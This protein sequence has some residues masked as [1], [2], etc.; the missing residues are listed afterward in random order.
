MLNAAVLLATVLLQVLP[1]PPRLTVS[2]WAD[3]YRILSA[4]ASGEPGQ[5]RTSRAEYQ[6]GIMD[7]LSSPVVLTLVAMCSAQVGKTEIVNNCVGFY[8]DQDP[9][10]VMVVQP[11]IQMAEAWSK[12]RLSPM[13]RDTPVLRNKVADVKSRDS[14]NTILDKSFPGGLLVIRGSNAPAGL[15]S[16]PIRVV[17]CDEVDRFDESAGTEGDPVDLAFKRTTTFTGRRKHVLIS[18]PGIKG[19]S[20]IEKAWN[21][22]DQR[23]YFVPCPHCGE[24]QHL[25]WK[26]VSFDPEAPEGAVYV[27]RACGCIITDA[28][29]GAMLRAGE[30]RATRPFNGTAG[31]HLN[32]MY[33]PWRRFGEIATDFMKAKRRGPESLKVWVNTSLGEPWDL[34]EGDHLQAEGL[35]ARARGSDYL[36]GAVAAAAGLLVAAVDVQDDRLEL[37]VWAVGLGEE[38][39]IVCHQIFPGNLAQ[40]DPWDRLQA[41]ILQPWPRIGGGVHHIRAAALDIGGHFTK[42]VY[43]FCRRPALRGKTHP[44]KG[45]TQPQA[46]L[47]RRSGA[48][49][50][51]WL[52]DTVAAKDQVLSRLRI[53]GPGFGHVHFPQDL[54]PALFDQFLAEKPVRRGGRRA[55]EKITADARNEGLDLLVYCAAALEIFNPSDLGVYVVR[56]ATMSQEAPAQEV[57]GGMKGA[58]GVEPPAETPRSAVADVPATPAAPVV[59]PPPPQA[60]DAPPAKRILKPAGRRPAG[61][62]RFGGIW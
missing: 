60:P 1:P 46:R 61:R 14:A 7:A 36:S 62:G 43:A 39:W 40:A 3:K 31:F 5:W 57:P 30:W 12:T 44:I 42:Q 26:Q 20:R 24:F 27:C 35:A 49:A 50:R 11:T 25:E 48:K 38:S 37:M 29:K 23:R 18:T 41:V 55:Y 13:L 59:T 10:P 2:E 58:P 34:R 47:V 19:H 21:E 9:S 15:A 17:L 33:S 8:I 56:A 54:E 4:E 16:Q 22:S 28:H 6:R 51:L 53:E 45:A 32:E 52:V